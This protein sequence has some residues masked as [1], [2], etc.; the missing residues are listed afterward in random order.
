VTRLTH[1]PVT[2]NLQG[3]KAVIIGGGPVAERKIRKL[4]EAEAMI[5]VISP[6]ITDI[7][8]S[9]AYVGKVEW[10]N[11]LFYKDD[12]LNAFL[13]VAATND[14]NMNLQVFEASGENQLINI[15]DDPVRSNFIVPSTLHR[16][17]LSISV[18]TSGAS[19]SLSKSIVRE[20]S[21]LYDDVYEEYVDFLY[22]C[23]LKIKRDLVDSE[24]RRKLLLRILEPD[25]LE[26]TRQKQ[27]EKRNE[28]F[29]SL[30]TKGGNHNE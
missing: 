9:W 16:G 19:P 5:T 21:N 7:I 28:T 13:I 4:L 6:T 24:A 8:Q 30:L 27:F 2:L 26:M 15:V 14:R 12:V 20:L 10:K 23:R 22:K 17:K 25:F 3:K 29:Q 18:S 1:Y 11:K